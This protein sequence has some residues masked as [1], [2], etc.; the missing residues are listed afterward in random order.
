ML[1]ASDGL[2]NHWDWLANHWGFFSLLP[3]SCC[4]TLCTLVWELL[5]MSNQTVAAAAVPN[6]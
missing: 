2:A 1:A 6:H 3:P 4:S 5:L